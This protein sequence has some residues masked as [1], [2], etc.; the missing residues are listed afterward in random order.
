MRETV[1]PALC[2]PALAAGR[3]H[4]AF[5]SRGG[6]QIGLV[7]HNPAR[8]NA[9]KLRRVF[10]LL[11]GRFRLLGTGVT[12]P[13]GLVMVAVRLAC[14]DAGLPCQGRGRCRDGHRA[15][16]ALPQDHSRLMIGHRHLW[17]Y[18]GHKPGQNDG[19]NAGSAPYV[20]RSVRMA[21]RLPGAG[22]GGARAAVPP[23]APLT[24]A[25]PPRGRARPER[26]WHPAKTPG[27]AQD[28][29]CG[30]Q[31]S[32]AERGHRR[33][34][35]ARGTSVL[36]AAVAARDL[37]RRR[38]SLGSRSG[39]MMFDRYGNPRADGAALCRTSRTRAE[40]MPPPAKITRRHSR[41]ENAGTSGRVPAPVPS[42]CE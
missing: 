41:S 9:G 40:G 18:S 1:L 14:R 42:L 36:G 21:R 29:G 24:R 37:R 28:E 8:C 25:P 13:W 31:P 16:G 26:A 12:G 22:P 35:A 27:I 2:L 19:E 7:S 38:H 4:A 32:F 6:A 17:R 30:P 39:S 5:G 11:F 10:R 15:A 23:G 3:L 34:D 20:L 33:W